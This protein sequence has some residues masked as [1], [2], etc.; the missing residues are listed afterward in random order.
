MRPRGPSPAE[1]RVYAAPAGRRAGGAG[2][3]I[4]SAGGEGTMSAAPERVT[5]ATLA[6]GQTED[7][8]RKFDEAVSRVRGEFGARHP[9]LIYG[10]ESCSPQE[11][12]DRSPADTRVVLGRFPVGTAE[13]VDRAVRAAREGFALWSR[14]P[15]RERCAI[16]R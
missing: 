2:A 16:L 3:A 10:Q 1:R 7:F 6:A 9:H 15:W 8:K 12:E 11:L 14:V 4:E 13:D 5:Y